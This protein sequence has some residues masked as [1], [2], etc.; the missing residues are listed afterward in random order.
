M[1][2]IV[3]GASGGVG[4]HFTKLALDK[5]HQVTAFVRSPAKLGLE[6]EQLTIIQGDAL[7]K[8]MVKSAITG[9]DAV[10]SCLGSSSGMKKSTQLADMTKIVVDEMVANNVQRIIYIASA[11][12]E[13]EIPG[14]MGKIIMKMLGN[15]LSDHANAVNYI[16][17][18]SLTYTIA[19]PMSL[20]DKAFTGIYKEAMMGVPSTGKSISRADVAD[21]MYKALMNSEY[22]NTSVGL[23]D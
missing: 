21:F 18:N 9:K 12:I 17:K 7:D 22:E 3:F 15:V 23:S 6:H 1:N 10:V 8:D 19:R 4:K 16:K 5:C 13:N 20:K 2:I 11:G 14:M